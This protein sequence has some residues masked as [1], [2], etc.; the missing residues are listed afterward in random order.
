MV[1][2]LLLSILVHFPHLSI[3]MSC[4]VVPDSQ[5]VLGFC[6]TF[7]MSQESISNEP[8]SQAEKEALFL[9]EIRQSLS[10]TW[11]KSIQ[12]LLPG[13]LPDLPFSELSPDEQASYQCAYHL[14]GTLVREEVADV[15]F[16][17]EQ[18][19]DTESGHEEVARPRFTLHVDQ[20]KSNRQQEG[21]IGEA[22]LVME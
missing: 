3:P 18:S 6:Y 19:L 17:H 7:S 12:E 13:Y 9:K 14:L 10:P 21:F 16:A 8:R 22:E 2:G 20:G 4:G 1:N 11:P 5:S 15:T